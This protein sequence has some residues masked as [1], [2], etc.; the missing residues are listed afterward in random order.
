MIYTEE[1]A[2]RPTV[3]YTSVAYNRLYRVFVP[4]GNTEHTAFRTII[5]GVVGSA[6]VQ[7]YAPQDSKVWHFTGSGDPNVTIYDDV[8]DGHKY[9]MEQ[10]SP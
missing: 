10:G 6:E 4:A 7:L 3:G 1:E 8:P 2:P 5:P 9:I